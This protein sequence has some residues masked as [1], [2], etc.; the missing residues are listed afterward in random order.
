MRHDTPEGLQLRNGHKPYAFGEALMKYKAEIYAAATFTVGVLIFAVINS[1]PPSTAMTSISQSGN[2][3]TGASNQ[4][5]AVA[6]ITETMESQFGISITK[7][8]AALLDCRAM[9][10]FGT[11]CFH[12]EL[13]GDA[14]DPKS[15][16]M[17]TFGTLN[18]DGTSY[19]LKTYI[20][21]GQVV[22]AQK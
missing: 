2:T 19:T 21:S 6:Q 13:V 9:T 12:N 22:I 4:S 16:V 10:R 5:E 14:D 17:K 18:L 11:E 7:R 15:G 3:V 20:G 8:E 1:P